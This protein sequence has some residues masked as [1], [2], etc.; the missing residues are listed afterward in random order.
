MK[1]AIEAEA[2]KQ[3]NATLVLERDKIRKQEEEKS[4]EVYGRRR[5]GKEEAEKRAEVRKTT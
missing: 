1:E 2:Q 3:L 4:G 5:A